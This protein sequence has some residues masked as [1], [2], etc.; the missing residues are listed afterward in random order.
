M[1]Y[2]IRTISC[3]C[4]CVHVCVWERAC[5]CHLSQGH[6]RPF[7]NIFPISVLLEIRYSKC[8]GSDFFHFPL[9]RN[10]THTYDDGMLQRCSL[11]VLPIR[12]DFKR[13]GKNRICCR[14]NRIWQ[15][16]VKTLAYHTPPSKYLNTDS[17]SLLLALLFTACI[18]I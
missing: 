7:H 16:A 18:Q 12:W 14:R 17:L 6:L 13:I 10:F 2:F 11:L 15:F 3:A 4:M 5:M 8:I 1:S 9:N